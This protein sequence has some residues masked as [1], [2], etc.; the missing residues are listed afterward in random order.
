VLELCR[1]HFPLGV[2]IEEEAVTRTRA[3]KVAT[4][5]GEEQLYVVAALGVKVAA[6][7]G[8]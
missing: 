2:G 5:V 8:G 1:L 4:I 7:E 6:E 3:E